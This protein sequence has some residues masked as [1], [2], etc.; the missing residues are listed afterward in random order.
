M[1]ASDARRTIIGQMK[2]FR[3]VII[4][5]PKLSM[6]DQMAVIPANLFDDQWE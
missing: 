3:R 1:S 5:K 6:S 2:P 4:V